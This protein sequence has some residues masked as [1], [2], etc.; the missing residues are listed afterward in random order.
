MEQDFEERAAVDQ[1][2]RLLTALRDHVPYVGSIADARRA[3]R[4]LGRTMN[5]LE[6]LCEGFGDETDG[7]DRVNYLVE[8]AQ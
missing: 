6:M 3:L 4:F 1:A 5:S 8:A 7:S 2:R